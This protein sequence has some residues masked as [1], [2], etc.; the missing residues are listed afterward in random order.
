MP[1]AGFQ[2]VLD[3]MH[4]HAEDLGLQPLDEEDLDDYVPMEVIMEF[5]KEYVMGYR[6]INVHVWT[7]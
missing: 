3:A 6:S 5:V 1:G 4:R 2:L 7:H